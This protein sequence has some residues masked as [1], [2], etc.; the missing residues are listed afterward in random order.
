VWENLRNDQSQ[1]LDLQKRKKEIVQRHQSIQVGRVSILIS[2][3]TLFAWRE[4][5]VVEWNYQG[6]MKLTMRQEIDERLDCLLVLWRGAFRD[7]KIWAFISFRNMCCAHGER[8]L[9]F[10]GL[11]FLE[12]LVLHYA[13]VIWHEEK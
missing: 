4:G 9:G 3:M 8:S 6:F 2:P 11:A 13:Y 1:K 5:R 7:R 10:K 12:Q